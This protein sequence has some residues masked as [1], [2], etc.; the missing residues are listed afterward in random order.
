ME[1]QVS[2]RK[3]RPGTFEELIGQPAAVRRA[4][5]A[6]LLPRRG[7][8]GPAATAF[9]RPAGA[10][11]IYLSKLAGLTA[12]LGRFGW[13]GAMAEWSMTRWGRQ[14]SDADRGPARTRVLARILIFLMIGVMLPALH[15]CAENVEKN[16]V[17]ESNFAGFRVTK[18]ESWRVGNAEDNL[19]N[20]ERINLTDDEFHK[21]LLQFTTT[22]LIVFMKHEEPYDD[23][24]PSFKVL[25]KP[26]GK[27][28]GSNPLKIV[29]MVVRPIKRL[30]S[31]FTVQTRKEVF[32]GGL[33]AAYV[34]V[35]F[36]LATQT[37]LTFQVSSELWV[38]PKDRHFFLIGGGTKLGDM[39]AKKEI[40]EIVES[41]SFF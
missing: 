23:V 41:I 31:N 11:S 30:F 35:E 34:H 1:Y 29:D 8:I 17:F 14:R 25:M 37:G 39:D 5:L 40:R 28:D 9:P 38:V 32:V 18:P 27:L 16:Y 21:L 2:A 19:R 24:N 26:L 15:A 33:K 22:P 20:L 13:E 12:R 6:V 3:F 10:T 7:Y 36:E 4:A